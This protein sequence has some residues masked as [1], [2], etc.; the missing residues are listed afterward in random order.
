LDWSIDRIGGP[1]SD[2]L[3]RRILLTALVPAIAFGCGGSGPQASGDVNELLARP[4]PTEAEAVKENLVAHGD[5]AVRGVADAVKKENQASPPRIVFLFDVL[6]SIG[7][8]NAQIAMAD[9]LNDSRPFVRARA[10]DG[11][12]AT[13]ARCAIPALIERFQDTAVY[14]DDVSTD[15]DRDRSRTVGDAAADALQ[16]LTGIQNRSESPAER[17]RQFMAWWQTNG[18]RLLCGDDWK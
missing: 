2:P 1:R 16:K 15:P 6:S 4:F 18:A 8:P 7:T 12:A 3:F 13:L 17:A 10:A 9:L 5:R 11:L 14:S